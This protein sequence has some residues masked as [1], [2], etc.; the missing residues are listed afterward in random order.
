VTPRERRFL[1]LAPTGKDA[2]LAAAFLHQAGVDATICPGADELARAIEEGAG[3]AL[4]AEEVLPNS[5]GYPLATVL[6]RQPYWSDFPLLIL[7]RAGADS[8]VV[9]EAVRTLGNVTL[10]ERPVRVAS[11]TSAVRTALRARARQYELR[12]QVEAL[13]HSEAELADM[14]EN[15][16]VGLHTVDAEGI[17]TRVNQT[18]LDLLGYRREEYV[19]RPIADFHVDPAFVDDLLARLQRGERLANREV[20][21]RARD[22]S[23]RHV[24]LSSDARCEGGRLV[25]ART[26]SVDITARKHAEEQLQ[27]AD[28]RKDEFLATL[29]HELRNPL[30]PIRNSLYLIRLTGGAAPAAEHVCEMMER[31]VSHMVRLV[32]DL[33]EVSRI[34]RGKIDMRKERIEL[35]T[36]IESALDTSRPGIEAARH[37]F[38]IELPERPVLIDGDLVRLSQVFANLL[39]NASKYTD[40][41]GEIRLTARV[42][43]DEVVVTVEDEGIGIPTEMLPRVFDLFTQTHHSVGRDQGG[44]GIGLTLVRSL[45]EM[46]GGHVVATSAGPGQGSAFAVHLPIA[47]RAAAAPAPSE[48]DTAPILPPKRV[49]VVDDNRDA[50]DSLGMLLERLGAEVEVVYDG[51][52]ALAAVERQSPE[53]VLLDIGMPGMDGYEVARRLHERAD[54]KDLTLV[55]MTGWGQDEDRRRSRHAGFVRHLIKPADLAA[56]R[57]LLHD[58]LALEEAPPE[59]I[60][61]PRQGR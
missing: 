18:E 49:L 15:A 53:V 8:E 38:T 14:F 47:R 5:G 46:H 31:Q 56:V 40:P 54:G 17:V 59:A 41:G 23:I 16:A 57:A 1:I 24:L 10:L 52:S 39:N 9:A 11:L 27:Q 42:A 25:E 26:F 44:L 37:H 20:R 43:G 3:A 61:R 33:M 21:L 2:T 22:G 4:V 13:R 29:A 58:E 32:D 7:T 12:D 19:G 30:A 50:A 51:P 45:V 34:T 6:R 55:A 36:V 60:G 28:R 48:D 35:A